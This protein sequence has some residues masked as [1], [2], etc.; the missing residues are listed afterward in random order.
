M[1]APTLVMRTP[2]T[3]Q[4]NEEIEERTWAWEAKLSRIGLMSANYSLQGLSF[5]FLPLHIGEM[6]YSELS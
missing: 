4:S 1:L 2:L 5:R 6:N 3:S